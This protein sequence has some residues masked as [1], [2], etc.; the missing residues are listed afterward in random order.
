MRYFT[1][2]FYDSKGKKP[3]KV[4]NVLICI[5][6]SLIYYY[7]CIDYISCQS[8]A[9]SS[10]ST[11]RIFK[12]R[13]YNILI[14]TGIPEVLLNI[15]SWHGLMDKP[16]PHIILNCQSC[17]VNKYLA[18]GL[19]IISNNSEQLRSLPNDVKLRIC[20]IDQL[21]TAFVMAK[22]TAIF[23]SSKHNKEISHTFWFAFDLQAK[24]LS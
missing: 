14:G 19:F 10:I 11:N 4:Y 17:L 16:N 6:Y 21:E 22:N 7:V 9:L 3:I 12:K 2:N 20:T 18:K 1:N 8:K 5:L 23:L 13:S 24:L 15:V